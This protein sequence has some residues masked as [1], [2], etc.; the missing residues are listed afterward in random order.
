MKPVFRSQSQ[1]PGHRSYKP[2]RIRWI[3]PSRRLKLAF[4]PDPPP[5]PVRLT[6][7]SIAALERKDA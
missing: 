4:R 7:R 2:G 5:H 6:I 1:L 3:R